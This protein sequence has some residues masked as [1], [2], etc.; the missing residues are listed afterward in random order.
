MQA[1]DLDCSFPVMFLG[2][3][4]TKTFIILYCPPGLIY[5]TKLAS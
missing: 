1:F 3:Q 5:Q 2:L 4:K